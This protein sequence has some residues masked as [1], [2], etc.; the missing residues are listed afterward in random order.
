MRPVLKAYINAAIDYRDKASWEDHK[1]FRRVDW[2]VEVQNGDTQLGYWD[3][4]IH[5]LEI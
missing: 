5:C 2:I 4:V 3:W 1:L